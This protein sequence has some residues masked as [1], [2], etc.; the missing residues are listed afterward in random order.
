MSTKNK[1]N[2]NYINFK[3]NTKQKKYIL[4]IYKLLLRVLS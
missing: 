2:Y 1:K 4:I 3:K